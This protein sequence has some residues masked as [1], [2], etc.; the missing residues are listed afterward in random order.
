MNLK[1]KIMKFSV[2]LMI[3]SLLIVSLFCT[4]S[5]CDDNLLNINTLSGF[6]PEQIDSIRN[7]NNNNNNSTG[8]TTS[9]E[10]L[11]ENSIASTNIDFIKSTDPDTFLSITYQGRFE[12]E[13]PGSEFD[14]IDKNAFVFQASFTNNKKIGIWCHS[15][16]QTV[17]AAAGYANKLTDKLGKLPIFM[18]DELSHVV[19]HT[20]DGGAFAEDRGKFFVIFTERIDKR[21]SEN[22]L[23]E[24]VF[25]ESIHVAIDLTYAKSSGWTQAQKNDNAFITNYAKSRPNKEDL[26]ETAIFVYAM[27][28][29]PGRIP[30]DVEEW[31]L[32]NISNRYNFL[33]P[34]LVL[35]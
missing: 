32:K 16:F 12:K 33:K 13:M 7:N 28:N 27:E 21:I 1:S 24:T 2:S 22:D 11:F 17:E 6:S 26:A 8:G 29:Y 23:E 5:S 30:S 31:V 15:S 10:P 4:M 9:V 34:I 20:G 14:L 3:V 19:I 25:H 18:R 35:K